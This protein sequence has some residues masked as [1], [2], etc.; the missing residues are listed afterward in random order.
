MS[1]SSCRGS[2]AGAT[3]VTDSTDD[4]ERDQQDNVFAMDESKDSEFRPEDAC[5]PAS[6][7]EAILPQ[8]QP[9]YD[10]DE[11]SSGRELFGEDSTSQNQLSMDTKSTGHCVEEICGGAAGEEGT[12]PAIPTK[13][14]SETPGIDK[15]PSPTDGD[16]REE[17]S[18]N[19]ETDPASSAPSDAVFQEQVNDMLATSNN[20]GAPGGDAAFLKQLH[21]ENAPR[22]RRTSR[23]E[24][25]PVPSVLATA[26]KSKKDAPR[27]QAAAAG[28][29]P[30]A[31]KVTTSSTKSGHQ[32]TDHPDLKK[33]VGQKLKACQNALGSSFNV[34]RSLSATDSKDP[35]LF[36][37][38][39]DIIRT[40]LREAIDSDGAHGQ[41]EG[42]P[43]CLYVCGSPGVGKTSSIKW[44]IK[45]AERYA[46]EQQDL[47]NLLVPSFCFLNAADVGSPKNVTDM[48][49]NALSLS[50]KR[51][52][53]ENVKKAL[54]PS[55]NGKG[56]PKCSC[57]IMVI[58]EIELLLSDKNSTSDKPMSSG[59][60]VLKM[61]GDWSAAHDFHFALVGISNSIGNEHAKRLQ[62]FGLVSRVFTCLLNSGRK[63]TI[64]PH[65]FTLSL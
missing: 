4:G 27:K 55:Q 65:T 16:T 19:K 63:E 56:A 5:E 24:K 17:L 40:F 26:S 36:Q 30:A 18:N 64:L 10:S 21:A 14:F 62:R 2:L 29:K 13:L 51:T 47:D 48:M 42:D 11:F 15:R 45:E 59:E 44:A 34:L 23:L 41:E 12:S 7:K 43:A 31:K 50:K 52:S 32:K 57:L 46:S 37:K 20:Q 9:E 3:Q 58:D 8:T 1:P 54:G 53:L 49:A 22:P 60:A 25:S 38:N 6:S 35:T 61:L 33:T 28:P 39:V